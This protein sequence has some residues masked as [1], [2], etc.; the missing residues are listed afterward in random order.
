MKN[1]VVN[2]L[3]ANGKMKKKMNI[4]NKINSKFVVIV[5]EDEEKSNILTIKNLDEATE[6]KVN[7]DD[8]IKYLK[9]K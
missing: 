2:E 7:M 1:N 9:G 6:E 5:G 3:N 4:S 8:L